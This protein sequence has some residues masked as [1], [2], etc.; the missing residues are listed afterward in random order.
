MAQ[1]MEQP[2]DVSGTCKLHP[3]TRTLT[4]LATQSGPANR[5]TSAATQS[6]P[7]CTTFMSASS[8]L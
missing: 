3:G 6:H 4:L 2:K 1:K 7:S 8:Q 5:I